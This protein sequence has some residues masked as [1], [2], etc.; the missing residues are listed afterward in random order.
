MHAFD[1]K[2]NAFKVIRLVRTTNVSTSN[3]ECIAAKDWAPMIA[4]V[5]GA[6]W[7]F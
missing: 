6:I 5:F 4:K 1:T 3:T 7:P 2:Y